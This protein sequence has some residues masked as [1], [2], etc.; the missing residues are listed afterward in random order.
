MKVVSAPQMAQCL[1]IGVAG[2]EEEEEEVEE[3][4]ERKAEGGLS[5]C[6]SRMSWMVAC[7]AVRLN[8]AMRTAVASVTLMGAIV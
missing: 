4:M 3:G 6:S 7:S 1:V 2:R 8:W 5:W